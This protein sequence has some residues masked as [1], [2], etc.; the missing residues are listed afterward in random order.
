MVLE[1]TVGDEGGFDPRFDRT[2]DGVE[3]IIALLSKLLV[4]FQVET[5][6]SDLTGASIR[7]LR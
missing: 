3:T 2:E 4:M 1:T 5:Y 6:L 7:I